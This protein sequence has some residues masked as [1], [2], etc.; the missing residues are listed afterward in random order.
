MQILFVCSGN[1]CRSP[2]AELMFNGHTPNREW[3]ASSAGISTWDGLMASPLAFA[4]ME[5]RGLSLQHHRSRQI[6]EAIIAGNDLVLTMTREHKK[7]LLALYPQH[8]E[9]IFALGEYVGLPEEEVLDP[10]G[11]GEQDYLVTANQLVKLL[12]RLFAKLAAENQEQ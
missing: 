1:T 3:L 10:F 8:E 5:E 4:E 6:N 12:Q 9:K 2:M 7:S 11:L